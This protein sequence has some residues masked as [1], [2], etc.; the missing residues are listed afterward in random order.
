MAAL[1]LFR[2]FEMSMQIVEK[3]G[4][5]LSRVYGV[6]ISAQELGQKLDARIA[7]IA[8]QLN[9]K[10]FRPGKVPAAHVRRIYG[11]SLMGEVVEQTLSE[12]S[13]KVLDDN[14]LR[15]A[16]QPDLKPESD[17]EK[18]L[19]GQADLSYELAVEVM[20]EF[21]PID[22]ATLKLERPIHE[23][24]AKDVDA[25]LADLAQQ[26]RT[27]EPRTGKSVKAKSGDQMVIDFAGR[28]DGEAF[29][30]GQ[31]DD[32]RLV[33]GA[34]QFIPG[35]EEQLTGLGPD[36][37]KTI[38]VTFPADYPV[39]NLRGKDAEF[40][41]TVKEV[42][43]PVE[44]AMDDE[45]AKRLGMTDLD[46][47]RTALKGQL[48]N[49]YGQASRYRLKRALLDAL[50]TGHSFGLPPRMV[51]AEFEVIWRQVLA[52]QDEG[53]LSPEDEGKSEDQLKAEYHKIA[54]RRVRLGLVL[55]EIG[56]KHEIS[57]SDEELAQAM[58]TEA[59]RYRGQ[60]QQVFDQLRQSPNAQATLR[61]PVY[62]DKVVDLL[63]SLAQV[64]DRPVSK[65]DLLKD[66][67]L[68]EAYG[69]GKSEAEAKPAKPSKAAKA[70]AEPAAEEAKAEAVPAAKAKP[71]KAEAK[72]AKADAK[73]AKPEAKPVK[74]EAKP[75]KVAGAP[76][77][78]EAKP[79]K[80]A[81]VAEPAK[82]AA[83]KAAAPKAK[84]AKPAK[85]A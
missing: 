14:Q 29:E 58:R 18:V 46:A 51:E 64:K 72:P 45:F 47:L 42:Q 9:L 53:G 52:D 25:A 1:V 19:A 10:G 74:A 24:T 11:R 75:A 17:M 71:A 30:G 20:P 13:Q 32:A 44:A 70:K 54:E 41:V 49:E 63:F 27:Y 3:S 38:K 8:P 57:V 73:P 66:D 48:E 85:G 83:P 84:A 35:F 50:D 15:V 78:A 37:T 65:E 76:A 67:D 68:P 40:D 33:L 43:A 81:K 69:A 22:P 80:T 77:K 2:K 60:E 28:V 23:P 61:A 21:E 34:G 62:E 55:A 4:E 79:A 7:E 26:A 16:S 6:S 5:G 36:A 31:A 82:A 12:T 39:A 56:R 59:M